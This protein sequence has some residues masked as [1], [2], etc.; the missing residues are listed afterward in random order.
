M[1]EGT[2]EGHLFQ[3]SFKVGPNTNLDLV[4]NGFVQ[5]SVEYIQGQ[6]FTNSIENQ[7]SV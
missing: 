2:S 5:L 3:T 6:R 7:F 4:A 1:F